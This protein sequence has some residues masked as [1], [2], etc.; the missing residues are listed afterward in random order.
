[1]EELKEALR[2]L[3]GTNISDENMTVGGNNTDPSQFNE[4]ALIPGLK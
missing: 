1:V 4:E 2:H 3:D